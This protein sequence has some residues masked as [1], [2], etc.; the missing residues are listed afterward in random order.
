M[1]GKTP[2]LDDVCHRALQ[3]SS[4]LGLLVFMSWKHRSSRHKRVVIAGGRQS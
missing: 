2:E 1:T 3:T 4:K